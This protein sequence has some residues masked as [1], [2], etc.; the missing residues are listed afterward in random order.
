MKKVLSIICL[1]M[2]TGCLSG[3]NNH[4]HTFSSTFS[5][6]ETSHWRDATCGCTDLTKDRGA[7]VD[8]DND[9]ECDVCHHSMPIQVN[10][11]IVSFVTNSD[12]IIDPISV[13]EGEAFVK[14]IDP[15]KSECVFMG[16]YTTSDCSGDPYVFGTRVTKDLTLYALWGAEVTFLN[17]DGS[18][19]LTSRVRLNEKVDKPQNP[20]YFDAHFMGW[21][22]NSD[23]E[24]DEFDF[25]NPLSKS[26]KLYAQF[27]YK[28]TYL[29]NDKTVYLNEMVPLGDR[30]AKPTD[31]T[32][33]YHDF[34]AWYLDETFEEK[35]EFNTELSGDVTLYSRFTP[36]KYAIT[37]HNVEG[38]THTNPAYY[39]YGVGIDSFAD[40]TGDELDYKFYGWYLDELYDEPATSISSE[41]HEPV[42]I[43]AKRAEQYQ[44]S[45]VNWP[46]GIDNPNPTTYTEFDEFLIDIS[47]I[48]A[49]PG[50]VDVSFK[51]N[52]ESIPGVS[53]GTT[54]DLVVDVYYTLYVTNLTLNPNEGY[55][56]PEKT[57][58]N[59]DL[60][61]EGE[62]PIRVEVSNVNQDLGTNIYDP[63]VLNIPT[64]SGKYFKGFS[65]S[66][67]GELPLEEGEINDVPN[68]STIY[69][70]YEDL[71]S[72]TSSL[73]AGGSSMSGGELNRTFYIPK[74]V[75]E[76]TFDFTSL[77]VARGTV[78][79]TGYGE[80]VE[81]GNIFTGE[82]T[83]YSFNVHT[84]ELPVSKYDYISLVFTYIVDQKEPSYSYA[85][86][87]A[88]YGS[89]LVRG[90]KNNEPVNYKISY[91]DI[92]SM[93]DPV[94]EDHTFVGW[95][96]ENGNKIENNSSWSITD[97]NVTLTAH[98]KYNDLESF[99]TRL[100][101]TYESYYD[102]VDGLIYLDEDD[103]FSAKGSISS[104]YSAFLKQMDGDIDYNQA[105]QICKN[106][107]NAIANAYSTFA[108]F[109][110]YNAK[111]HYDKLLR[112]YEISLIELRKVDLNPD[113]LAL[114][115]KEM[116]EAYAVIYLDIV[117]A[118]N[119]DEVKE[120]YQSGRTTLKE[121]CDSY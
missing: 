44:I 121:I 114:M 54:G 75:K 78:S 46:E 34:D 41:A 49:V 68:G 119:V 92:F 2:I 6:D 9:G 28:V 100:T 79:L 60:G 7:H 14:P 17:Y 118:K 103:R 110:L 97:P 80:D 3:C 71:P 88:T 25:D 40:P 16:W 101:E 57:Y 4:E 33:D 106:G 45:Y 65:Y 50:F 90:D 15:V 61:V 62:D 43:Y 76:I 56:L 95:Y 21:Y 98:Y 29:A 73:P 85:L 116:D 32:L 5:S 47:D 82:V 26:V 39:T 35:F 19:Y 70:M 113:K 38:L 94:R 104:N 74:N 53:L 69:A 96:D 115:Q 81:P 23:F 77:K 13:K 55:L 87:V 84:V 108:S 63:E 52:G 12:S 86:N 72:N 83:D 42:D 11:Y 37:Y 31:P 18:T 1:A 58:I 27:G 89:L 48:T 93:N 59:A 117:D 99:K 120:I 107:E 10:K 20:E 36:K 67:L 30:V 22:D 105:D 109:N 8:T 102:A 64:K 111:G 112:D 24:G 51:I 91:S 66:S